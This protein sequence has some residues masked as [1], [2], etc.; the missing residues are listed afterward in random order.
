MFK[1]FII[2]FIFLI[3]VSSFL[4]RE[5]LIVTGEYDPLVSSGL[6]GN[7]IITEI[8]TEAFS[9][10]PEYDVRY[11]FYPWK[12]AEAFVASGNAWGTY[13]FSRTEER[14]KTFLFSE[15]IF[16]SDMVFFNYNNTS[17][18]QYET[19][20]DLK[21]YSI[22]GVSGYYYQSSFEDAGLNVLYHSS[23]ELAFKNLIAGRV[24]LVPMMDIIGWTIIKK[25]YP[26]L[27]QKFNILKKP[28]D[29][30]TSSIMISKTYTDSEQILEA[31]NKALNDMK[32]DGTYQRFLD[33]INRQYSNVQPVD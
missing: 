16:Q 8:I 17:D 5:I 3:F 12:R 23:E 29:T 13:P 21:P 24:D 25:N 11:E 32:K 1:S 9:R 2:L 15:I 19:L 31:F 27:Q 6:P 22:G 4:G 33:R 10:V 14:E 26:K 20:E 28:F 7:G 18:I 30:T